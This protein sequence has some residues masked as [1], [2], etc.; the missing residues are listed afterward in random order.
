MSRS[1]EV[2]VFRHEALAV[3]FKIIRADDAASVLSVLAWQRARD[4]FADAWALPSGPVNEDETLGAC[5]ARH[6]ATK[7]DLTEIAHLEQLETRSDPH[8]DPFR[9]TIAT[10][11]LGLV[12]STAEP[13]LPDNAAWIPVAD[14][15]TMAFD[16]ASVVASA[17]ERLQRKLSYSNL[18]FGLAPAT[19]TIAQLRDIYSA[20]LGH[21][22]SATNLQRVLQRRGQI[23]A[24]GES[25][26]SSGSGGRP[27]ALYRFSTRA[28]AITDP[29][30]T[31]KP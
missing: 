16:H 4:P 29:F 22:V 26:P 24:T 31:F 21:E 5:V 30:A 25:A 11:Y 3:V 17:T 14:L 9:R 23:E 27:A 15:P 7:V 28:L 6:L 1:S 13:H 8:R 10:A 2:P 19:F 12:P 18:G 20:A